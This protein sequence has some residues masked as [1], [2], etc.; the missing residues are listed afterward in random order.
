LNVIELFVIFVAPDSDLPRS[1]HEITAS[2]RKTNAAE[3]VAREAE[4]EVEVA[5]TAVDTEAHTVVHTS[6]QAA[7]TGGT[8]RPR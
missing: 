5:A 8:T 1:R 2:S 7:P 4:V 6:R 3:V